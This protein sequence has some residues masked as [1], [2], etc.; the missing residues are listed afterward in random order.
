M[1]GL[2]I[3]RVNYADNLIENALPLVLFDYFEKYIFSLL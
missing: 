2:N 1:E 3:T